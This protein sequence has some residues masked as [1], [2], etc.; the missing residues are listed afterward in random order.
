MQ[1]NH[2]CFKKASFNYPLSFTEKTYLNG[3]ILARLC[4][5]EKLVAGG[6]TSSFRPCTVPLIRTSDQFEGKEVKQE[7]IS[8]TLHY[9]KKEKSINK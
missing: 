6:Y 3:V 4:Y 8:T 5:T 7:N 2:F 9:F 1:V